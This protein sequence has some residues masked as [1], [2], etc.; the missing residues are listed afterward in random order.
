[1]QGEPKVKGDLVA[2]QRGV[3]TEAAA[4]EMLEKIR[5]PDG[6]ACIE[7]GSVEVGRIEAKAKEYTKPDGSKRF[8]PAR[9]LYKCKACKKQFTVTKGT[10]FEDSKIPLQ[11]WIEVMYRMCSSKKGISAYQIMREYGLSYES[12]WFMCHRIRWAMT[13]RGGSLLSGTVE[14]DETYVGGKLRGPRKGIQQTVSRSEV[15]K[16]AMDK[17]TPVFG[18]LERG[19]RVRA[20]VM[21]KVTGPA[22]HSALLSNID[23]KNS[24]LMTDEAQV[25]AAIGKHLPHDVIRHKSEYVR[26]KVHTNGI[27]GFW[28]GLKRQLIGTHHHVDAGYL[29]MYVQEQAFRYNARTITDKERFTSLLGQVDGRLDWYV[30]KNAGEPS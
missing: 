28:A 10:I 14:A 18:I 22:T 12:A 30:G 19:G 5:W 23:L 9:H 7:C 8:V 16:A 24:H 13:E 11:M 25:Y 1:M 29:N 27:E 17:K 15:I 6:V 2:L 20:G 21:L 4:R 3:L 26:G